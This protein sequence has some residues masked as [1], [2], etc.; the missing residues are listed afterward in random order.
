MLSFTL[1]GGG[2]IQQGSLPL[3]GFRSRKEA[4]LLFYLAH[5]G[6]S[7]RREHL[8]D[9]L[10]DGRS[11][12]RALSNLRT[13]LARLRKRI[14]DALV[15]TRE[16]VS[17]AAERVGRVDSRFLLDALEGFG[18]PDTPSRADE[19]RDLLALHQGEFLADFYL[20]D[21]PRF[22]LW[23]T[24]TREHIRRQV[25]A[26]YQR[27]VRC[28]SVVGLLERGISDVRRWLEID[29]WNETAHTLLIQML[30]ESDCQQE[31]CQHYGD[32][33]R[34]F[35]TELGIDPPAEMSILIENVPAAPSI[36]GTIRRPAESN[37]PLPYDPFFGRVNAQE[38]INTCLDQPWC[39]LIT[40][41]GMGGV[42]KTRLAT[43]IARQRLDR[44]HN[45]VWLVDLDHLDPD[46]PDPSEAIAVEIAT[47]LSFPLRGSARPDRQLIAYLQNQ[48]ML[49]VLDNYEH[50]LA[51]GAEIVTEILQRCTA[52]QMIVTSRQPL[53]I[54]GESVF[55]LGGLSYSGADDAEEPSEAVALFLARRA[56]QRWDSPSDEELAAIRRICARVEGLPLA[57]EL[58][59]GLTRHFTA[60]EIESAL[61]QGFDVLETSLRDVPL[62]HRSLR[63]VFEMSWRLLPPN[64]QVLL[65]RLAVLESGFDEDAAREIAGADR[66]HLTALCDQSLLRRDASTRHYF[67]HPVIRAYAAEKLPAG[68]PAPRNHARLYLTRL[69]QHTGALQDPGAALAELEM[70]MDNFRRA[71]RTALATRR[72]KLL[73]EAFTA[74]VLCHQRSELARQ[75]EALMRAT[76]QAASAW[77][78]EGAALAMRAGVETARF[79]MEAGRYAAALQT[80]EEVLQ[81]ARQNEDVSTQEA[82]QALW[83]AILQ[84]LGGGDLSGGQQAHPPRMASSPNAVH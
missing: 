73:S 36:S 22:D 81:K 17:L 84:H 57:I 37:L 19:L 42:G 67:L 39:R 83:N 66:A 53:G 45:G 65:A 4:A 10:W 43:A 48:Q 58:S 34:L 41:T 75:G 61:G 16:D 56:Q 25:V 50:L 72:E 1:L 49:L 9:L 28:D 30:L 71:W 70:D 44:A 12:T 13:V 24:T 14:G 6:R 74:L 51:G 5:T 38:E 18:E 32:C 40:L 2:G 80:L 11:S 20:P 64:S 59:A 23:L 68:D 3:A 69:A 8:A 62:R 21:A 60:Q 35:R 29:E 31:A 79:Q 15:T 33:E 27:L 52:V 46:D 54:R 63:Q 55:P 7:H 47:T 77:G 76:V 26:G 82:V 78:A